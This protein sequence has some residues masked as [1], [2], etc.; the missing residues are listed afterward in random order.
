MSCDPPPIPLSGIWHEHT[1]PSSPGKTS[2]SVTSI[3][4]GV[5]TPRDFSKVDQML[6]TLSPA[7]PG[8]YPH[9][10][11]ASVLPLTSQGTECPGPLPPTATQVEAGRPQSLL[12]CLSLF[13]EA[14]TAGPDVSK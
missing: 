9:P 12:P 3:H 13:T 5:E 4:G 6:K 14:P 11:Q 2:I 7:P 10:A 1:R 8:T